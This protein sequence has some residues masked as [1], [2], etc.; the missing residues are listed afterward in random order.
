MA[1][2]TPPINV[3]CGNKSIKRM[4]KLIVRKNSGRK[5]KATAVEVQDA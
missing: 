2:T 1:Q 4:K 5:R 3:K